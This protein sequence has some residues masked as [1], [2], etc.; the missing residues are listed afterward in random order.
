MIMEAENLLEILL[1]V[2][3]LA[4]A[5]VQKKT[6]I[7]AQKQARMKVR[8]KVNSPSPLSFSDLRLDEACPHWGGQL[9]YSVYN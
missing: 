3:G 7:L 9:L 6:D 2:G 8:E 5:Q 4:T 1:F